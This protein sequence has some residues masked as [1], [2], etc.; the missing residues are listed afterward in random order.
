VDLQLQSHD[1]D[2]YSTTVGAVEGR[3]RFAFQAL[4][5]GKQS[6]KARVVLHQKVEGPGRVMRRQGP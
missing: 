3:N 2:S 6:Q 5:Q 1:L 4:A